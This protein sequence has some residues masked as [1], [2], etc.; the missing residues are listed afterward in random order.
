MIW[1]DIRNLD[2]KLENLWVDPEKGQSRPEMSLPATVL[3]YEHTLP[4]KFIVGAETG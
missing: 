4:T 1:W 2:E 3:E